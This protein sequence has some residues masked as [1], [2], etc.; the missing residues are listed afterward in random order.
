MCVCMW[1]RRRRR[2]G[3]PVP[4]ITFRPGPLFFGHEQGTAAP[5]KEPSREKRERGREVRTM[6]AIEREAP[7]TVAVFRVCGAWWD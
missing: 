3:T 2:G 6:A 7:K 5:A 1:R 4:P